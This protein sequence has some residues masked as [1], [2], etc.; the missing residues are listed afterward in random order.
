[1]NF[2]VT[3]SGLEGQL[4]ALTLETERP[5]LEK[6]KSKLL[7]EEDQYRMELADLE[8]SLLQELAMS[9][10]NILENKSLIASL[11]KTKSQSS[12]IGEM[13]RTAKEVQTNLDVQRD[14]YRPIAKT[15]SILF[16]L[17]SQVRTEP[18]VASV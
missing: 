8:K 15:G 2:T 9:E 16:F 5:E 7:A 12:H 18:L 11:D 17:I 14:V 6:T 10:G 3:R 4:L 13:L 1:M